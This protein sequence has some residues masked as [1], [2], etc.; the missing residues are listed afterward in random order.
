MSVPVSSETLAKIHSTLEAVV[1][2]QARQQER[3]EA[4]TT[5]IVNLTN[6]L[7][8]VEA[9]LTSQQSAQDSQLPESVTNEFAEM[10]KLLIEIASTL[11]GSR[12]VKLNDGSTVKTSDLDALKLMRQLDKR[13]TD[14]ALTERNLATTI[15]ERGQIVI[16]TDDIAEQAVVQ[17]RLAVKEETDKAVTK[18]RAELEQHEKQANAERERAVGKLYDE[19]DA[20]TKKLNA[21]SAKLDKATHVTTWDQ[22]GRIL[23]AL[24]PFFILVTVLTGTVQVFA[25]WFGLTTLPDWAWGI[26]IGEGHHPGYLRIL[27]F[28]AIVATL[29]ALAGLMVWLGK[30]LRDVYQEWERN[31]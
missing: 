19:I 20:A 11:S 18:M 22:L 25:S 26:V 23:I 7:S 30:K 29:S 27:T 15:E 2:N 31:I 13:M 6:R 4:L 9:T 16:N 21:A 10:K 12:A 8:R 28:I 17:F 24:T 14:L 3:Q 1:N 5:E